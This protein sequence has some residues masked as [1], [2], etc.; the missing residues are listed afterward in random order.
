MLSGVTAGMR[1]LKRCTR[2]YWW[3]R[4]FGLLF[5]LLLTVLLGEKG[6]SM[7][8]WRW[9]YPTSAFVENTWLAEV[10][11]KKRGQHRWLHYTEATQLL[12]SSLLSHAVLL[13]CDTGAL[14]DKSRNSVALSKLLL[15]YSAVLSTTFLRLFHIDST[16][17]RNYVIKKSR[18]LLFSLVTSFRP[19][20]GF[21]AVRIYARI[22][23]AVTL[24]FKTL[25]TYFLIAP[26]IK[27]WDQ[28]PIRTI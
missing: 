8:P 10:D 5:Y 19:D 7:L 6:N 18:G 21:H 25:R 27:V 22:I 20:E 26:Y 24:T 23:E 1:R 14:Q 28:L 4:D 3:C 17:T 11:F 15:Y 12:R 13:R 2:L 9:G 16:H